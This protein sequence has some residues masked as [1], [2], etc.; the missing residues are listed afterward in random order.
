L[1]GNIA[2]RTDGIGAAHA[3]HAIKRWDMCSRHV[4][5][6]I[7]R[8]D[9]GARR[10]HA[11]CNVVLHEKPMTCSHVGR[12]RNVQPSGSACQDCVRSDDVWEQLRMCMECGHIG[13]C[14]SSINKHAIGHFR[15]TNHPLTR[16]IEPGEEWGW[17]YIDHLWFET[18][19]VS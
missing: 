15:A 19:V 1:I 13:C 16:S 18:L 17:C 9:R 11:P 3:R 4:P 10:T 12:I 8:F 2:L 5:H 6:T 7:N 14:D